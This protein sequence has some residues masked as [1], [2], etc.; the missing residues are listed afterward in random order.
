MDIYPLP[1]KV[2]PKKSIVPLEGWGK[3]IDFFKYDKVG[4]SFFSNID[5]PALHI[6][7]F[8]RRYN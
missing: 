8:M 2:N 7:R 5:M 3:T 1:W 6:L 4:F